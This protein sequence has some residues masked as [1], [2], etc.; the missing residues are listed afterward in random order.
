MRPSQGWSVRAQ[1]EAK[2]VAAR[3]GLAQERSVGSKERTIQEV[4]W[5]EVFRGHGGNGTQ[6]CCY[7]WTVNFADVKQNLL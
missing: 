4:R 2:S 7:S 5:T 1:S 3:D 6:L